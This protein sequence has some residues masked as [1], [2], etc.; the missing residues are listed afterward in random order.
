MKDQDKGHFLE[1]VRH[2]LKRPLLRQDL[3]A[4]VTYLLPSALALLVFVIIPVVSALVLSFS[5]W[6][7]LSVEGKRFIGLGN[8]IFLFKSG[9]FWNTV[10]NTLY[11]GVVK[12]PADIALSLMVAILLNRNIRGLSF[13][14]TIYFLPVITSTVAVSAV[15][16]FV[17]DP[18]FGYA[19]VV[20]KWLGIGP[21]TWLS[22]PKLAMPAVILVALWKGL[23][24]DIIIYLAGLQ[25]I[26]RIYYEA[27][28]ID[29]ANNWRK[30]WNVTWPLLSPVTYFIFIMSIINSF[31]VFTQIHVMTPDGGPLNSTEVM[32]LYI[33]RQ[34]FQEYH[35]GRA[36]AAA[37]VL[38]GVVTAITQIQRRFIE[39]RV[40]YQ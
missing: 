25:A 29:G 4:G 19:N 8:Y 9:E 40:H 38:F 35:F 10:K 6:D 15:W 22:D 34:A 32:V 14:R 39:S 18:N 1:Q 13:Y 2:Y 31:K 11:F 7:L 37:F 20:L 33:Y 28:S 27:A 24:Y 23:G 16:R 21:Q 17:Y 5:K 36:A 12:I 26:P 30:F 3:V